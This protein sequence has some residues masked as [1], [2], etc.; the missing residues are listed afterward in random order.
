MKI[1]RTTVLLVLCALLAGCGLLAPTPAPTLEPTVEPTAEPTPDPTAEPTPTPTPTAEPT[2]EPTPTPQPVEISILAVGDI[3]F[4]P[5]MVEHAYDKSIKGYSFEYNFQF[6]K[7]IIGGA[8]L[9]VGNFECTLGGPDKPYSKPMSF[10]A[11]D[12][13]A[14]ALVNAGFD[15]LSTA[16]NHSNDRGRDGLIR[17]VQV[18]REKGIVPVGSRMEESEKPYAIADVKGIK[19][20]V[21]GYTFG[22][23]NDDILNTFSSSTDKAVQEMKQVAEDM[24]ADG[25]EIVVFIVHWG[26]EYARKPGSSQIKMAQG[27]ADAG[28]DIIFGSHPHVLQTVDVLT[29]EVTGRKTYVA[30]STGNFISNQITRWNATKF[31][32]TEDGMMLDVRVVKPPE[33]RAEVTSFR[34]LPTKTMLNLQS[35]RR[36]YTVLP[37]E[38]ALQNPDAYDMSEYEIK[39]AKTSLEDTTE[40]LA[41]AVG[42][43]DIAAMA[44]D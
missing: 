2:P 3:M 4:H 27:L 35:S 12:E 31:K 11:P 17:T 43:G 1:A 21:T 6:V 22:S 24:R 19:V 18:M 25:A 28:V 41:D 37:I 33:G 23:R 32:Y 10:S 30:Y 13:A 26:S 8:D 20:G 7:D 14:D 16:N 15:I 44:A 40:L 42:E 38:L 9:A 36:K 29:S 39:K 34:Y 5:S